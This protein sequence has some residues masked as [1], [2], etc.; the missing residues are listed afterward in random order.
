MDFSDPTKVKE[1]EETLVGLVDKQPYKASELSQTDKDHLR[2]L[3]EQAN[4]PMAARIQ[5]ED[6]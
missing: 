6:S 5:F 2:Y 1:Y 3:K 4:S